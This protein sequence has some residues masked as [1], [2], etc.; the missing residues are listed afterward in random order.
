MDD[1]LIRSHILDRRGWC[2]LHKDDLDTPQLVVDLDVVEENLTEMANLAHTAGV[3]LRPHAKTH[4]VPALARMQLEAGAVGI[5]LAK[6]SEAEVMT[7]SGVEDIF[8]AYTPIGPK[9]IEGISKLANTVHVACGVDSLNGAQALSTAF[10]RRRDRKKLDVLIEV[11]TGFQ[12]CGISKP[13]SVL[14]LAKAVSRLPGLHFKGLFT[15]EGQVYGS[16]D[17]EEVVHRA[18]QAYQRL[19]TIVRNLKRGSIEIET[20]SV[21]SSPSASLCKSFAGATEIRPGVYIFNDLNQVKLRGIDEKRC[22][23]TVLATVV[24]RPTRDRAIVDAGSKALSSD[25]GI[26]L[27]PTGFG[28][29]RGHPS[30]RVDWLNEEHGVLRLDSNDEIAVGDRLELIPNHI[31]PAVNNFDRM[32]VARGNRVEH[33]WE[34]TARGRMT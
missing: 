5:T 15:Y 8:L 4:K 2:S 9:K 10:R 17:H 16:I 13:E 33:V 24:S 31:C 11:D 20:V 3:D 1:I 30:I 32:A 22:A 21:G 7:S 34:I 26:K 28:L 6:T 19:E 29:V 25:P 12:R 14:K 18:N 23:A 27:P